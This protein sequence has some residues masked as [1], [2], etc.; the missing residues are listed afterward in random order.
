V[1]SLAKVGVKAP[2]LVV[3]LESVATLERRVIVVV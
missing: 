3:R 1:V 2:V